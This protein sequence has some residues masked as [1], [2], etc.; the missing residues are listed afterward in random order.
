MCGFVGGILRRAVTE[1][2]LRHFTR[3]IK[4]LAHRGPDDEVVTAIPE[5]RAILAF[6]RLSIID[7]A[8]GRQPMATPAGDHLVFN[9]EIYDYQEHRQALVHAGETFRTAS[10]TEVLLRLLTR[11]GAE[12]LGRVRGMF[13]LAYL[14]RTRG[15]LLL[16]RD[17]LGVKSLYFIDRPE[18]FFFASE[19]KAL[20]ALPWIR[21]ELD[22]SCLADYLDRRSVPSPRTLFRDIERLDP[23]TVLTLSL[24]HHTGEVRQYWQLP[25]RRPAAAPAI[26]LAEA[27]DRVEAGLLAAVR[28]RLVADVPVGAFLSGGLDSALIVAA[29]RRL[30]HPEIRAFTAGFP[31]SRDDESSFAARVSA[32]FGVRQ[33]IVPLRGEGFLGL[34]PRWMELNDDLVADAS[35]LPLLAVSDTARRAGCLVMLSGEGADELFAGYGS[36]H[37]HV[38]LRRLARQVPS[39]AMRRRV[40]AALA[41]TGLAAPQDLPRLDAYFV[42]AG[43]YLG[44]AALGDEQEVARI[45]VPDHLSAGRFARARGTS[46]AEL[47]R[48][49]LGPRI[50]DD[51][52][53]R[54]DRA[55]M[56]ASIEARVPFL[57]HEFVETVLDLPDRWRALPGMG[58]VALRVLGRRWG[59]PIQTL[60]HRKIGFQL[61]LGAWFRGAL[62]PHWRTILAERAI[63]ALRYEGIAALLDAHDHRRGDHAELLWRIFALE[64]WHRRWIRGERQPSELPRP[65]VRL[66]EA[67]AV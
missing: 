59:L 29:M 45:L 65:R 17:R 21:A 8:S 25:A 53:V 15:Q 19:P 6:R 58:K 62:R 42:R 13:A 51:L 16:A 33:E 61:P 32:R 66:R 34:L 1:E 24:E 44:A 12:A 46:L 30:G 41:M 31:G 39:P 10:D 36:Q 57:D 49:D 27:V 26:P 20:L 22:E 56:G 38:L 52:L 5:A 64:Q 60:L 67:V 35:A 11:H 40:V 63:P 2:H 54:T 18:G 47:C 7:L 37:K 14:D 28:R 3:S 48:F 4:T 55:T 50:S 43:D 9:G 23:G